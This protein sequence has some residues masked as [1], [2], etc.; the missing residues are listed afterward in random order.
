MINALRGGP[1][2]DAVIDARSRFLNEAGGE[3]RVLSNLSLHLSS[4]VPGSSGVRISQLS[5]ELI[6]PDKVHDRVGHRDE[7]TY[8]ER[9][10]GVAVAEEMWSAV[11]G[12]MDRLILAFEANTPERIR[13]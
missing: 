1:L 2:R 13:R 8:R 10:D 11:C 7:L 3:A 6:F 9:R 4:P 12:L 5:A